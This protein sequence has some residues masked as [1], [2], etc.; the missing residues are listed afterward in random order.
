MKWIALGQELRIAPGTKQVLAIISS[1]SCS[2]DKL[3][4]VWIS[5][6]PVTLLVVVQYFI[7]R[8]CI[9]VSVC[10]L[11]SC[12]VA[13]LPGN[14]LLEVGLTRVLTFKD[15][16]IYTFPCSTVKEKLACTCEVP[17]CGYSGS[18]QTVL[19]DLVEFIVMERSGR[20]E[21]RKAFSEP[22]LFF[23]SSKLS[24]LWASIVLLAYLFFKII[25]C[26]AK[27]GTP[28]WSLSPCH[29]QTSIP[30]SWVDDSS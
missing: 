15:F 30:N 2:L 1:S 25:P 16:W 5:M 20:E 22:A 8:M 26:I 10:F 21:G 17:Q 3:L 13:G 11:Q 29:W 9:C 12:T 27:R 14:K 19:P 18:A 23:H 4:C 7:I 24:G 28:R 6:D